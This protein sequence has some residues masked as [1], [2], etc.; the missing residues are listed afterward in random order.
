MFFNH[1]SKQ[2]LTTKRDCLDD[3]VIGKDMNLQKEGPISPS[4]DTLCGCYLI[5]PL[6]DTFIMCYL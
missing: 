5:G 3:E 6:K 1:H 4:Q 2:H